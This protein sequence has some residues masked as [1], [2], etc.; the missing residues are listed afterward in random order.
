MTLD[1]EI[2]AVAEDLSTAEAYAIID[3]LIESETAYIDKDLELRW[4]ES[5]ERIGELREEA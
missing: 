1:T 5:G 4:A 3:H 2:E